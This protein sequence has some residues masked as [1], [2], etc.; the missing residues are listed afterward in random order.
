[1]TRARRNAGFT[2]VELLVV[3]GIIAILIGI[4]LPTLSNARRAANMT[5]CITIERELG[6]AM[7]LYAQSYKGYMPPGRIGPEPFNVGSV[8][9][10]QAYIFWWMRLQQLRFIP[11][12]EDPTRGVALCPSHETPYWPFQEFPDNKNLQTSYGINP[13]MSMASDSNGDNI[14]DFQLHKW[15][16]VNNCSNPSEKILLGEV[17][18]LGWIISWYAP[19]TYR[20]G[21]VTQ[22]NGSEW[23]DFDWYRHSTT[24]GRRTGGRSNVLYLDGH[25][26]TVLQGADTFGRFNND[27][28]SMWTPTVGAKVAKRAERQWLPFPR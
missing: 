24:P 13:K 4:L 6:L 7:Q 8:Q 26:S 19:N 18:A 14:C 27:V 21:E 25:V 28:L 2:L 3:I 5:K 20:G 9:V 12:L 10:P 22:P 23:F 1:M 16:R 11:G 15:V 17:R